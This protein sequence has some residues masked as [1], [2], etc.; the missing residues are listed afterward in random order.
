MRCPHVGFF[1]KLEPIANCVLYSVDV[2]ATV[3]ENIA[4]VT[5]TQRFENNS[6]SPLS[7]AS[8][9]FPLYSQAAVVGFKAKI[10]EREVVGKVK[11]KEQALREYNQA[12]AVGD[13]AYLLEQKAEDIFQLK[14][15]NM[16][17]TCAIDVVITLVA[18]LKYSVALGAELVLPMTIAPRYGAPGLTT[19][20]PLQPRVPYQ[21]VPTPTYPVRIE[22][23]WS[24]PP[25]ATYFQC[26]SPSHG[27]AIQICGEQILMVSSVGLD[28]DFV[29][30][31]T[32]LEGAQTGHYHGIVEFSDDGEESCVAMITLVPPPMAPSSIPKTETGDEFVFLLDRSGS[33]SGDKMKQMQRALALFVRSLPVNCHLNIVG[34]GSTFQFLW[35]EAQ[36]YSD[37]LVTEVDRYTDALAADMGGTELQQAFEAIFKLPIVSKSGIRKIFVLT[38]GE[39]SD[40]EKVYY[41]I[42]ANNTYHRVFAL[43]IGDSV[44]HALVNGM[45]RAGHGTAEFVLATETDNVSAKVMLQLKNAMSASIDGITLNWQIAPSAMPQPPANNGDMHDGI[46]C[47]GCQTR[48]SAGS[49]SSARCAPTLTTAWRAS[50]TSS[51]APR[52]TS[53]TFSASRPSRL[54]RALYPRRPS[55]RRPRR[56]HPPLQDA[57]A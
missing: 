1:H 11:E 14:V 37:K 29:L 24:A 18:D 21:R 46:T 27:G 34:F 32:R 12:V 38:D 56:S 49:G 31:A 47:D 39:V 9:V 22:V 6:L 35:P 15:G 53:T 7:D 13:G 43:G 42:R 55:C 30:N 3:I 41:P 44:S 4:E 20:N 23:I 36:E 5:I 2:K 10:G 51:S 50:T 25:D 57:R 28:K 17:A 54:R 26:T 45:A 8:Y 33:M 52:I 48:P 16:P 40:A 19:Y